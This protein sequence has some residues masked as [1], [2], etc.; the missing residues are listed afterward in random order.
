MTRRIA[1]RPSPVRLRRTAVCCLAALITVIA[2]ADTPPDRSVRFPPDWTS[3]TLVD[4]EQVAG[5]RP[6]HDEASLAERY[7]AFR[8]TQATEARARGRA[9]CRWEITPRAGEKGPALLAAEVGPVPRC[10]AISLWLK[11][12]EGHRALLGMTVQDARG[13]TRSA[14]AVL[15][16]EERNWY[17]IAFRIRDLVAEGEPGGARV[18]VAFPLRSISLSLRDLAPGA[19]HVFYVDELQVHRA[20]LARLDVIEL[21]TPGEVAAGEDIP[22]RF[23][24]RAQTPAPEGLTIRVGLRMG[25][26]M[27]TRETAPLPVP[28]GGVA[29]GALLAPL[30]VTLRTPSLA[31]PGDYHVTFTAEAAEILLPPPER[32]PTSRVGITRTDDERTTSAVAAVRGTPAIIMRG[33]SPGLVAAVGDVNDAAQLAALEKTPADLVRFRVALG[34]EYPGAAHVAWLGFGQYDFDALEDAIGRILAAAPDALLLPDLIATAPASWRQANVLELAILETQDGERYRGHPSFSSPT[35]REDLTAAVGDLVRR[36]EE[37][38]FADHIAGYQVSAGLEGRWLSWDVA[39][40]G[41][42][43][44]SEPQRYAFQ[45]WLKERYANLE[46]LRVAWGQPA[47]PA[48]D[49]PDGVGAFMSWSEIQLPS[50]ARRRAARAWLLDPAAWAPIVDYRLFASH[51][52]VDALD[53]MV[54]AVR[55]ATGRGKVCGVAYGHFMEL[56]ARHKGLEQGGHLALGRALRGDIVDFLVG[57]PAAGRPGAL[58]MPAASVAR[59]Q[60]VLLPDLAGAAP[61]PL[62]SLAA[63][64]ETGA[65]PCLPPGADLPDMSELLADLDLRSAAEVA[66]IVDDESAAHFGYA[67]PVKRPLLTMQMEQ[68]RRLGAPVDMWLLADALAGRIPRYRMYVFLNAFRVEA[69]RAS[70]VMSSLAEGEGLYVWMCAPGL[71]GTT[72]SGRQMLDLTGISASVAPRAAPLLV[73]IPAPRPPLIGDILTPLSYGLETPVAPQ[74]EVIGFQ[75]ETLGVNREGKPA[76]VARTRGPGVSVFSAAPNMPAPLLRSLARAAGVHIYNQRD[77]RFYANRSLLALHAETGGMRVL[78]LPREADVY[79]LAGGAQVT[80]AG[81][82]VVVNLP[83]GATKLFIMRPSTEQ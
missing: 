82:D 83:A 53:R 32:L 63:C 21:S 74:V 56:A 62:E 49:Q 31:A 61:D 72:F 34:D 51:A 80:R 10:D 35:W 71:V 50:V 64:L 47:R 81:R 37:G 44:Y 18:P 79:E 41:M 20:P 39:A 19:R 45:D 69:Q 48:L 16:G 27:V 43:D 59:R 40:D 65:P 57:P 22:V 68:M 5:W 24:L 23:R 46:A 17:E 55:E 28:A 26:V 6:G 52:A 4:S 38:P 67:N 70:H 36:L 33:A 66:V 3:T 60:K 2:R 78:E 1:L 29:A 42:G 25:E 7:T 54:R 15:V 12:P 73:D 9:S 75:G 77:D 13:V 14:P 58:L 76:L 11:N 8:V 30:E